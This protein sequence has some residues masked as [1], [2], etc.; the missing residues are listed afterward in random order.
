M[1]DGVIDMTACDPW[2]DLCSGEGRKKMVCLCLPIP[3]TQLRASLTPPNGRNV[4]SLN[5]YLTTSLKG[6]VSDPTSVHSSLYIHHA[7]HIFNRLSITFPLL[8]QLQ[9]LPRHIINRLLYPPLILLIPPIKEMV[10]PGRP[11]LIPKRA[12]AKLQIPFR[13]RQWNPRDI[14]IVPHHPHTLHPHHHMLQNVTVDHPY[15][16][17]FHP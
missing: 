1:A 11:R 12:P 15:A 2:G 17:I 5:Q 6:P 16:S 10:Y 13:I 3:L 14:L 4:N 9:S 8:K 7:L